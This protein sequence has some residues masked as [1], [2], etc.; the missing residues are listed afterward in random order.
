MVDKYIHNR[1]RWWDAADLSVIKDELVEEGFYVEKHE[2]P[3]S[4]E[5]LSLVKD[6]RD[7]LH[8]RAD[9]LGA[10]LHPFKATLFQKD[11][12]LFTEKDLRLREFVLETYRRN[13]PTMFPWFYSYEPDFEREAET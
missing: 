7:H 6:F 10:I 13:R 1:F 3:R 9:T 12:A 11:K 5:E 2:M 8:I 4:D